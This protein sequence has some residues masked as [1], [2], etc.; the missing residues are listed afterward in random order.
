MI[1]ISHRLE[2]L[3]KVA[4]RVTVLR[5]GTYVDTRPMA[6]VD[7]AE[8]IRLMV[9]REVSAV[10]PKVTVP[11]GGI[12][13]ET[14]GVSCRAGGVKNVSITVRAGEILGF[15]GLMGAGRTELARVLFGLTPA[16]GGS[17]L[18]KGEQ[19]VI[20]SPADAV[21]RGIAYVPEDRRRHGVIL[22]MSVWE[23]SSPISRKVTAVLSGSL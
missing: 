21:R 17:I 9:G 13:L 14:I 1:Y 12:V 15:A 5:D 23:N 7:R 19:V 2:E 22:D 16:D 3:P 6:A 18:L 11:M 20:K 4:D 8:L 10:F